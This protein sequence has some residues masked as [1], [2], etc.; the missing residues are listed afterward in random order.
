MYCRISAAHLYWFISGYV[1]LRQWHFIF[2]EISSAISTS[3]THHGITRMNNV[4][5]Q[6][7]KRN[8]A[9]R[10]KNSKN[11][12]FSVVLN[13]EALTHETWQ[14]SICSYRPAELSL[15]DILAESG[16]I[17]QRVQVSINCFLYVYSKAKKCQP[18]WACAVALIIQQLSPKPELKM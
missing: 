12:I 6:A 10:K 11:T 1:C 14:T 17:C 18:V 2:M 13:N 9:K 3:E 5:G 7:D 8:V 15:S 4:S 16:L